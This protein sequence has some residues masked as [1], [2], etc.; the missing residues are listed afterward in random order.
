MGVFIYLAVA[1][2]SCGVW[3]LVPSPRTEPGTWSPGIESP[4]SPCSPLSTE[5][6]VLATGPPGKS[7][8]EHPHQRKSTL[9]FSC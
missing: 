6:G 1:G 7:P 5:H 3:G 8:E 9:C 2:L 4:L